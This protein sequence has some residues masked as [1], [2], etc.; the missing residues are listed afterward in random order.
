[1]GCPQIQRNKRYHLFAIPQQIMLYTQSNVESL[2]NGERRIFTK[3]KGGKLQLSS[4]Q[5][6][7]AVKVGHLKTPKRLS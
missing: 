3:I 6:L 1:M 4:L 7:S 2:S 5:R